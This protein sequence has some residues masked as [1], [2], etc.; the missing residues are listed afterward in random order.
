MSSMIFFDAD[1]DVLAARTRTAS[2]FHRLGRP[3][4]AARGRDQ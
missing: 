4:S 2:R 3:G 1:L